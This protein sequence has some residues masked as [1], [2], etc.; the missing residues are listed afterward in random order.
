MFVGQ[1]HISGDSVSIISIPCSPLSGKMTLVSGQ[2]I[3]SARVRASTISG[4]PSII[5]SFLE[6]HPELA[7]KF[8]FITG[9]T[10]DTNTREFL[11]Q[12][13][14]SYITK[15]FDRETLLKRVNNPL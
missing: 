5:S 10:S 7:G 1:A 8:I 9:D 6:A 12:N 13:K 4:E 3:F 2:R 15:P 14:L 11:E